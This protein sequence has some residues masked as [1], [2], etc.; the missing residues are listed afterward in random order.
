MPLP[1]RIT[2][3]AVADWGHGKVAGWEHGRVPSWASPA[4]L[5]AASSAH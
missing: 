2:P 1:V 4:G 3:A 5:V